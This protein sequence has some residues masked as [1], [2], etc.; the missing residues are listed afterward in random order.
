MSQRASNIKRDYETE[1]RVKL[2]SINKQ[3]FNNGHIILQEILFDSE[4]KKYNPASQRASEN[5]DYE[6]A[7]RVKFKSIKKHSIIFIYSF[8][9]IHIFIHTFIY[10]AKKET[11]RFRIE[12]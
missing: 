6:R 12:K 10:I 7:R 8:I 11:I 9:F 3:T 2:L 1:K 4:W 5:R